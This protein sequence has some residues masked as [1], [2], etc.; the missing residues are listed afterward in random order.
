MTSYGKL[1]ICIVDKEDADRH[2]IGALLSKEYWVWTF[3]KGREA[4]EKLKKSEADILISALKLGD[5]DGIKFINQAKKFHPQVY[6]VIMASSTLL[7][8]KME[9]LKEIAS[10]FINKPANEHQLD[11]VLKRAVDY[12]LLLKKKEFYRELSI[13][14]PLTEVYNRRY[15]DLELSREIE[16][17]R[18]FSHS[19]SILFV[20]IDNFR[21]YNDK[22]GHQSG[23]KLLKKFA[24]F[25]LNS[26]R[27]M[28]SVFRYGGDEFIILFPETPKKDAVN[29]AHRIEE[30]VKKSGLVDS[31]AFAGE[32]LTCSIGVVTFPEDGLS[33]EA[34]FYEADQM[35]YKAKTLETN[36]VYFVKQP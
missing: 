21:V 1:A 25:L 10:D 31:E 19:F 23:D 17:S 27:V 29:L 26:A 16:R 8:K 35:M 14:D 7:S 32:T 24:A 30:A 9:K 5:M 28:D 18:R 3:D 22:Y 12:Q 4:L 2:K 20:D 11:L 33:A 6:V 15:L 34:L 13:L 36:K